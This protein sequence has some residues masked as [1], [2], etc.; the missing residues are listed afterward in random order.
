MKSYEAPKEAFEMISM[1]AFEIEI[2]GKKRRFLVTVDHYSDY[3]EIDEL[4][5]LSSSCLILICKRN[6]TE[7]QSLL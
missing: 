1:D 5:D 6:L 2:K 3:F 4:K 7:R